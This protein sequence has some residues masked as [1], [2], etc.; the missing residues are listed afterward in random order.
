MKSLFT[1]RYLA[2]SFLI[3]MACKNET[4]DLKQKTSK[5]TQETTTIQGKNGDVIDKNTLQ[6]N[7]GE[8]WEANIETTDGVK[9]MITLM[10]DF[11][12]TEDTAAYAGLAEY[13]KQEFAVIFEK[14][15]MKGEAHNQLHHFLIPINNEF[16]KLSSS[17]VETCKASFNRLNDHLKIY[18]LYFK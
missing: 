18:P 16:D 3:V 8:R 9:K 12:L 13:L 7:N 4:T 10:D 11:V 14:C 2:I 15:T 6:L 17:N 1:T 5:N